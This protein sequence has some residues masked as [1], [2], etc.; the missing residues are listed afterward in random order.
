MVYAGANSGSF[1]QGRKDLAALAGIEIKT[2]RIRRAT[3]RNGRVRLAMA[4]LLEQAFLDKSLPDQLRSGP[5]QCDAPPLAVV[6]CD[7][8]K[9]QLFD[10]GKGKPESGSFWHESR[11]ACLLS[12]T[13]A[14]YGSDPQCELPAFLQD[15]SIA[16]KL[17]KIGHVSGENPAASSTSE[18]DA[19]PPWQHGEMLS[20]EVIASGRNWK[21]FGSKV[22]SVAWY[23][24]FAK[25]TE[26]V[27]VSDGSTTIESLQAVWF[28]DYISVLDIM[29]A[30]SYSLAAARAIHRDQDSAWEHYKR[31][32]GWIWNGEVDRVLECLDQEQARLGDPP[33]GASESDPREILRGA[34]VYYRNHRGRMNYPL[35]RQKGYPLTSS[36][37]ESTVKQVSRRVKGTEK[38]WSGEGGEALLQLRGD[39]LSS[40]QPMEAHW[41][42]TTR[43]A[44]GLRAY[45][46]SA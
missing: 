25:A 9:Y 5:A 20:K 23:Q 31:L 8:G 29:H 10:R 30:L 4:K 37:M 14:S 38:F 6:M 3:T 21:E 43:N 17:A 28:S 42:L 40:S 32:A 41:R 2:E 44:D 39:Y 24:G 15:V 46:L 35:Y 45:G 16:K 1:E 27:F 22:A 12:M 34:R 13:T 18:R 33:K 11:V 36:I 7:G 26:K 19:A